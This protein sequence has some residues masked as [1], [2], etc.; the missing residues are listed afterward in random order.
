MHSST[1]KT[2][3]IALASLLALA[4]ARAEV[5]LP[6]GLKVSGFVDMSA[7]SV[8]GKEDTTTTT[9]FD[10]WEIDFGFDA[11]TGITGNVDLNDTG[12]GAEVEQA[13]IT[14]ALAE[15]LTAK[16]GL[17]LTPLGYEAAEPTGLYQ[18]S[19]SAT[20]I[21]Y[22]GY[23][24]GVA[25]SYAQDLYSL[26]AAVV[27]GSYSGNSE[28]D[29]VSFETQLKLM[30][31][32]GLTLQAGF[33]SEKFDGTPA[34]DVLLTPATEGYDQGILNFWAEYKTGGLTLAAEY[35]SL[36]EI[37]EAGAD[38][39]GYLVMANYKLTDKLALTLRHSYAELD[40]GYENTEYT[41]SPSYAFT[42]NLLG[43][44]EARTDEYDDSS[45]DAETYAAEL[46][47]TF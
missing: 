8:D 38:G 25:L 17:F 31:A 34:D 2:K 39:D 42:S 33:A 45:A 16:A 13:F 41:I 7:K 23:A 6:E 14:A 27:D 11:G 18:Y 21:G 44:L 4:Y 20:I 32:E 29:D 28:A 15:G 30:P 12:D 26:Y 19:V 24:N 3:L 10:Q 35:N 36:M 40:N 22:P 47:F 9:S 5:T 37:G 1:S 46:L 43:I